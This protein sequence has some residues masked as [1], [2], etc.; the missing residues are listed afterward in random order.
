[1]AHGPH[2][3]AL[4]GSLRGESYTRRALEEALAG[5]EGAGGTGEL[6]DLRE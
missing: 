3:A 6:I 1:M 4:V 5:V 2:V